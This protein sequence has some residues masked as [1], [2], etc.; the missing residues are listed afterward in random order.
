MFILF[1]V[2]FI[3][4]NRGIEYSDTTCNIVNYM[5]MD[6]LSSFW[7]YGYYYSNLIGKL[8]THLPGGQNMLILN[9]YTTLILS[10]LSLMAYQFCKKIMPYP[11][12]FFS[13]ILALGFCWCPSL[14]LY[15]Y[16]TFFF[17]T[18]SILLLHTG[19]TKE[20]NRL[21]FAAGIILAQNVFVRFPNVCEAALIV[22]VWY[23]MFITKRRA[24]DIF[25]TTGLCIG[26]YITGLLIGFGI[27]TLCRDSASDFFA[28]IGSVFTISGNSEGYSMFDMIKAIFSGYKEPYKFEMVMLLMGIAGWI[29]FYLFMKLLQRRTSSHMEKR[30]ENILKLSYVLYAIAV[31]GMLYWFYARGLFTTDYNSYSAMIK[32]AGIMLTMIWISFLLIFCSKKI[33]PEMKYLTMLVAVEIFITPFGSNNGIYP[34]INNLFIAIPIFMMVF[35]D[36]ACEKGVI[37]K[38]GNTVAK[39]P[40]KILLFIFL[41]LILFQ[42][43]NFRTTFTFRDG[44][45]NESCNSEVTGANRLRGMYTTTDNAQELSDLITFMN[46]ISDTH[47]NIMVYGNI[48]GLYYLIDRSIVTTDIWLDLVTNSADVLR[49]DMAVISEWNKNE[50]P[51]V[52]FGKGYCIDGQSGEKDNLFAVFLKENEYSIVYQTTYFTVY[53][54]R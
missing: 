7:K 26:G 49:E 15:N 28:M 53:S 14:S 2:P 30:A 43:I 5:N 44:T 6:H 17:F 33:T 19:V 16:L 41:L 38:V 9:V 11:I 52:I 22:G 32:L 39:Y 3:G 20:R 23:Y 29:F 45:E 10:I 13:G 1:F 51:F 47:D 50:K 37:F 18:V 35:Y 46:D 40:V 27:M 36:F 25:K 24:R 31:I 12:A 21:V 48:P 54:C 8:L 42:T 34:V 4:V